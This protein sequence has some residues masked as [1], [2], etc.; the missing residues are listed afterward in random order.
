MWAIFQ[1]CR[2]IRKYFAVIFYNTKIEFYTN[3]YIHLLALGAGLDNILRDFY[4]DKIVR[5]FPA[6]KYRLDFL[7]HHTGRQ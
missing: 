2:K 6:E 3:S 5:D 4:P 7:L 1:H